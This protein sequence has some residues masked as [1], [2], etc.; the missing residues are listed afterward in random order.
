LDPKAAWDRLHADADALLVC[1]YDDPAACQK[2][3]LPGA[4]DWQT[5]EHRL[6]TLPKE[7]EVILYCA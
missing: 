2:H 6:A 5:F 4:T 3:A 1:A 7:R